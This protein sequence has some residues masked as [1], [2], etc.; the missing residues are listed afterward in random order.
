MEAMILSFSMKKVWLTVCDPPRSLKELSHGDVVDVSASI[1]QE[2]RHRNVVLFQKLCDSRVVEQEVVQGWVEEFSDRD[3][4]ELEEF[5]D[6]RVLQSGVC[7]CAK[8][9]NDGHFEVLGHGN[10]V[11][12]RF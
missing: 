10:V 12:D 5:T 3:V 6:A 2:F 7:R 8:E 1:F 11:S 4:V 9:L